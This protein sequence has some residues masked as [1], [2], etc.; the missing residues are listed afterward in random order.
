VTWTLFTVENASDFGRYGARS[1]RVEPCRLRLRDVVRS[2][3]FVS[4]ILS[5]APASGALG[6]ER[7]QPIKFSR[8]TSSATVH[9]TARSED[10]ACFTL[11]TGAG[12][13]ATVK[14]VGHPRDDTAFNIGGVVDNR[15]SHT[16]KTKATTYK[17]DVYRTFPRGRPTPFTL[18]VSVR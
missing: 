12:Q 13:T 7:C 17:I 5:F 3:A 14:L 6:A 4:I 9:G 16:F 11:E 15:E 8:G 2:V 1:A 18:S 10:L